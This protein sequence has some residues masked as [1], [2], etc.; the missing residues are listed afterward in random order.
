MTERY[1]WLAKVKLLDSESKLSV[2]SIEIFNDVESL[3]VINE[4]A[5]KYPFAMRTYKAHGRT[6]YRD[7]AFIVKLKR[8]YSDTHYVPPVADV[9]K[10]LH[11][12]NSFVRTVNNRDV[13]QL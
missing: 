10:W 5:D 9:T 7:G 4:V 6:R 1:R 13:Q 3:T 12:I 11:V 8:F 2:V